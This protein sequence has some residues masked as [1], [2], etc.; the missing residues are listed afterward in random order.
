MN[1]RGFVGAV[2]AGVGGLF[3][4]QKLFA[5]AFSVPAYLSTNNI[6]E[7]I[8]EH[9]QYNCSISLNQPVKCNLFGTSDLF[10]HDY[11]WRFDCSAN[12]LIFGSKDS[13]SKRW[14][15]V[16]NI[17]CISIC[18]EQS[19][20]WRLYDHIGNGRWLIYKDGFSRRGER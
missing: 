16:D 13:E 7:R 18:H 4:P 6:V 9:P 8:L 17:D 5:G 1:R 20:P 19:K 2:L 3:F 15:S 10:L 11:L 14:F 12:G